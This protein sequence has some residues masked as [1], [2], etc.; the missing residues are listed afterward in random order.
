M[1]RPLPGQS[2]KQK[3]QNIATLSNQTEFSESKEI[4]FREV[5]TRVGFVVQLPPYYPNLCLIDQKWDKQPAMPEE[6]GAV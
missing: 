6:E 1:M 4:F 3:N 5:Q 2:M